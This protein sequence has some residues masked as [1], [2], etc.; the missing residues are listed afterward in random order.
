MRVQIDDSAKLAQDPNARVT[1]AGVA[2]APAVLNV[3]GSKPDDPENVT[4]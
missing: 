4:R 1:R 3:S 2:G